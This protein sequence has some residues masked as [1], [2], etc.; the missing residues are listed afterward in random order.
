M[1]PITAVFLIFA[2]SISASFEAHAGSVEV[3]LEALDS[4]RAPPYAKQAP[5]ATIPAPNQALRKKPVTPPLPKQAA[6]PAPVYEELPIPGRKPSQTAQ[7]QP[8][9]SPVAKA[10]VEDV[11]V[12]VLHVA[13]P[14]IDEKDAI[15]E[16]EVERLEPAS[17]SANLKF[18]L[19]FE[20]SQ[21]SLNQ[22]HIAAFSNERIEI[23]KNSGNQRIQIYSFATSETAN[24][25]DARRIS[26]T[27]ALE[28]R[29]ILVG[30]GID[31]RRIDI[32]A[33][34]DH[35]N[36]ETVSSAPSN[37]ASDR[38]DIMVGGPS[39]TL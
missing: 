14:E 32:V 20:P 31:S 12:E 38:I 29:A 11:S 13:A 2:I 19:T 30:H 34:G 36:P 7:S 9:L 1:R 22:D 10:P 3:N 25:S 17:G 24:E 6:A 28:I 23:I 15:T 16:L 39:G 37:V 5:K 27:R 8:V 21:L 18:S 35:K 33:M 26:L 4:L